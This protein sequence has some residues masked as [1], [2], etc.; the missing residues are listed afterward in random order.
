MTLQEPA[1]VRANGYPVSQNGSNRPIITQ[2]V[3][4]I[5]SEV[6]ISEVYG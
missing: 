1:G 4:E 6:R 3:G 5:I 2:S